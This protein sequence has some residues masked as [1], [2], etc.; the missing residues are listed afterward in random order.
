[1]AV[2]LPWCTWFTKDLKIRTPPKADRE[3]KIIPT[4]IN[5]IIPHKTEK[6]D[7]FKQNPPA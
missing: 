5:S 7:N 1:M 2:L 4:K 3:I 6:H